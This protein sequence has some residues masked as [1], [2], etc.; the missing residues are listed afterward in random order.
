MRLAIIVLAG[1]LYGCASLPGDHLTE[2]Q[3]LMLEN[4]DTVCRK[5]GLLERCFTSMAW[6]D[7]LQSPRAK[8]LDD[9]DYADFTNAQL[10]LKEIGQERNAAIA[11]RQRVGSAMQAFSDGV[12]QGVARPN[13]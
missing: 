10:L 5:V 3:E 2:Y 13:K 1:M 12:M 7:L 4:G 8:T 9:R 11:H 6:G